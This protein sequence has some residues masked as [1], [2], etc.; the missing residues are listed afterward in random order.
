LYI[1]LE[2]FVKEINRSF[3][4][5]ALLWRHEV[6]MVSIHISLLCFIV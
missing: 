2:N 6:K 4:V 1:V 5:R 3:I